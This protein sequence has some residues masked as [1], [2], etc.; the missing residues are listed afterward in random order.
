MRVIEQIEA[1]FKGIIQ[2]YSLSP[3]DSLVLIFLLICSNPR[4]TINEIAKSVGV[5]PRTVIHSIKR[6]EDK[7]LLYVDRTHYWNVYYPLL[8]FWVVK[9]ILPAYPSVYLTIGKTK[10]QKKKGGEPYANDPP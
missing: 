8:S 3:T 1:L 9:N 5:T 7:G 10:R 6:L 2:K 4:I